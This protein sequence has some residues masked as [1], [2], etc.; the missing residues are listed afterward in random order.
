[1]SKSTRSQASKPVHIPS[2]LPLGATQQ[3]FDK[4]VQMVG[5]M[6]IPEASKAHAVVDGLNGAILLCRQY[7]REPDAAGLE[8]DLAQE[9]KKGQA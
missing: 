7:L 9:M 8:A 1:M 4:A 2:A 5:Q 3:Q 6:V